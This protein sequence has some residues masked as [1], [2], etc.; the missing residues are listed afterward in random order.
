LKLR[1]LLDTIDDWVAR[2]HIAAEIGPSH[3]PE[4]TEVEE[5]PPLLLDLNAQRIKT[6]IWATGYR[7]DYSWLHAPVLD[8]KGQVRHDGGVVTD[9]PGMYL[10][11]AKFLRRRKSTFIDG[12]G[13]DARD[14]S[15]HLA[16]HLDL[17]SVH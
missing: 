1:R 11:G 4:P 10:L 2:H 7:A 16:R 9:A 13:E 17:L 8:S 6:V 15:R 14:L 3:R 5:S 12:V